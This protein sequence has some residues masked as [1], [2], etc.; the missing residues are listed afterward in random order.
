MDLAKELKKIVKGE[1]KS[2]GKTLKLYSKDASLLE[3][4][5]KVVVFPKHKK[6]IQAVVRFVAKHKEENPDLG[7]TVRSGGTDMSGAAIGESIILDVNKYLTDVKKVVVTKGGGYAVTEPGAFYRDFEKATLAK[8]LIMPSF[9]ASREI[10]TVGGMVANNAGGEN[11]LMYGK[12]E[13]YVEEL[14]IILRDGKEYAVKAITESELKRK[15]KKKGIEGDLY[16]KLHSLIRKNKVLLEKAKPKVSKNSSGYYLWNVERDGKFDL[17][18]ILVGSQGTLGI[19]TEIKMRLIRPER[20]SKMLVVFLQDISLLGQIVPKILKEK[21]DT[22][23]SYDDHTLGVALRFLPDLIKR[24][25][26]SFI[27]LL[28][29]FLPEAWMIIKGGFKL[30]K[31]VILAEFGGSTPGEAEAEARRARANLR[32]IDELTVRL[33]KDK[34]EAE[35][36]R[37]IRRESFNLLRHKVRG[38][39][40]APFVDDI[41]V[42]PELLPKFW[43]KLHKIL[44]DKRYDLLYTVTGHVGNGNFHIIPL[45]ELAKEED[46]AVIPKVM[47]EVYKLVLEFDGSITAE[48]NDGIVRAPYLRQMFGAKVYKLFEETKRIFDPDMIFNPGKKLGSTKKYVFSHI[49]QGK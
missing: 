49:K 21:P 26:G 42:R 41:I 1:V 12:V 43:P 18:R 16:R 48:H 20:Y 39:Q 5:P 2:D 45:M 8:G 25:R 3:I 14:K 23:E 35:K 22:L 6:D 24:L 7:I 44:D 32:S 27:S 19:I 17:C 40:T 46:R 33:I 47:D 34:K 30:P 38:K 4:T 37:L 9:P 15:M 36:Y 11:T 31:L 29:S 13:D 10:C 28:F